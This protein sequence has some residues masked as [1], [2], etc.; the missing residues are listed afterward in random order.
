MM[1]GKDR[2]DDGDGDGDRSGQ[3]R[4]QRC[5][6]VMRTKATQCFLTGGWSTE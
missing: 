6:R 1:D 2:A 3:R 4:Q 5:L